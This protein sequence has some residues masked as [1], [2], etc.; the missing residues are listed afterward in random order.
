M[1][2]HTL[3]VS[4]VGLL[5]FIF[6]LFSGCGKLEDPERAEP[7][8]SSGGGVP[9]PIGP[10][11]QIGTFSLEANATPS[12]APADGITSILIVASLIDTS[13]RPVSGFEVFFRSELG[14][15]SA[16]PSPPLGSVTTTTPGEGRAVTDA[17]GKASIFLV[18]TQAGSSPV[19]AIADINRNGS[20]DTFGDLFATTF[21][22]FTAA[23]GAPGPGVAGIVLT[24]DPVFQTVE[25]TG[26]TPPAPEPVTILAT[27]FDELGQRA[28]AGVMVE[29]STSFGAITPFSTTNESGQATAT[30]TIPPVTSSTDIV[31]TASTVI[32]GK[33]FTS[34]VTVSVEVTGPGTF[35]PTPIPIA[36][37]IKLEVDKTTVSIGDTF[38][39]TATVTDSAGNLVPNAGVNFNTSARTCG[40]FVTS[41]S[42]PIIKTT[43][44]SGVA[45]TGPISVDTGTST[46]CTVTFRA[47]A[48]SSA[49]TIS[50]NSVTISIVPPPPASINLAVNPP[51]V[52]LSVNPIVTL[53][54]TARDISGNPLANVIVTF[55]STSNTCSPFVTN[56]PLPSTAKT[57]A[58]GIAFIPLNL[59]GTSV[60]TSLTCSATFTASSGGVTSNPV[61][62]TITP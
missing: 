40:T 41:P 20:V 47:S 18:S 4:L 60:G 48:Q 24:A 59:G 52:S 42:L 5:G 61:S 27:V 3:A 62:V 56:P 53:T 13:G 28:G 21:V 46:A 16:S 55:T 14:S 26:T 35:T 57:D 32:N 9:L 29:F 43:N 22:E 33:T 6:V 1:K 39:L 10:R 36:Q 54:A 23:P 2:P 11:S 37:G 49:G 15:F 7:V 58:N 31:V 34:R 51:S 38:T 19:T 50:S 30:L 44:A 25:F 17:N 8:G 45:T 12:S